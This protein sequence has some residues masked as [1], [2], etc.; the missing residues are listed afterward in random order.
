MAKRAERAKGLPY[1]AGAM[2]VTIST[3][4]TD[5]DFKDGD[6]A[7]DHVM[8]MDEVEIE[9]AQKRIELRRKGKK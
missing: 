1:K 6:A 5:Q 4:T 9:N 7:Y 3:S 2:G 8:N